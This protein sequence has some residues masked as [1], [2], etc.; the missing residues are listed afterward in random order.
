ME[1]ENLKE[2]KK[3]ASTLK[4]QFNLGKEGISKNFI[5]TLND[6]LGAHNIVKIKV[7]IAE[8][9]NS[10][11]YYAQQCAKET[12]SNLADTRGFTFTLFKNY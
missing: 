10:L 4:P 11:K 6:Y 8:D 2:A 7:S 12:D 1:K 9:K 5:K 3:M